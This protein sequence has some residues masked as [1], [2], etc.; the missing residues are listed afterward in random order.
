M[1][2]M[3]RHFRSKNSK[4][5]FRATKGRR[6]QYLAMLRKAIRKWDDPVLSQICDTVEEQDEKKF[7]RTLRD[8][9]LSTKTGV[10]LAAPQIG[11]TKKAIAIRS[12]VKSEDI[13]IM[14]NPEILE[15][16]GSVQFAE[17]CLSYPG[18][19][20]TVDRAIEVKVSWR[21]ENWKSCE[22]TFKGL[23]A[24]VIQHEVDH[25]F[26]VCVVGNTWRAQQKEKLEIV[27]A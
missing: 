11:I 13:R 21:D 8:T 6:L 25:L 3:T 15:K 27:T 23:D 26:G 24:I 12:D 17:G 16:Q 4:R 5:N 7:L 1:A 9:L 22:E 20:T 2:K 10:G 19:T 14:I 18:I